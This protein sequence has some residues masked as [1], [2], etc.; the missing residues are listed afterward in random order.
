MV[1]ELL[2]MIEPGSSD[3]ILFENLGRK[4]ERRKP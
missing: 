4:G 1:G 3:H 2:E